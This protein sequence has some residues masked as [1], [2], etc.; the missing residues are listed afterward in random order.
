MPPDL[1]HDRAS[2]LLNPYLH[3][4]PS[5]DF[6]GLCRYWSW[7]RN[8]HGMRGT[9]VSSSSS[10]S[11][12]CQGPVSVVVA[13]RGL[14]ERR[15]GFPNKNA[16]TIAAT[17]PISNAHQERIASAKIHRQSRRLTPAADRDISG[18]RPATGRTPVIWSGQWRGVLFVS[19]ESVV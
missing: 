18:L 1:V 11:V 14:P 16:A 8:P 17:N 13:D 9:W 10:G 5:L 19:R 4:I 3:R 6:D 2:Q 12:R 7:C 15:H